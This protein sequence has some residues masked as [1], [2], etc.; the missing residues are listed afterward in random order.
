MS[1]YESQALN[2]IFMISSHLDI[3]YDLSLY[4]HEFTVQFLCL[5]EHKS[6]IGHSTTMPK[7][8]CMKMV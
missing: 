3:M 5:M 1:Y 4:M 6:F 2:L 7:Y 8:T